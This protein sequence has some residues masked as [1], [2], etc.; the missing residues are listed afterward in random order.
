M[1]SPAISIGPELAFELIPT[2]HDILTF[3]ANACAKG[4][5]LALLR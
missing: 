4:C 3:F 2:I 5:R 1:Q